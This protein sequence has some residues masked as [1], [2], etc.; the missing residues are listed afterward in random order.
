MRLK[1]FLLILY[2]HVLAV[3]RFHLGEFP[4]VALRVNSK[5]VSIGAGISLYTEL[6][7]AKPGRV[8]FTMRGHSQTRISYETVHVRVP[9]I[10]VGDPWWVFLLPIDWSIRSHQVTHPPDA[11]GN[12]AAKHLEGPAV[13]LRPGVGP[14]PTAKG[15]KKTGLSRPTSHVTAKT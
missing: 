9:C 4:S 5:A 2:L 1:V 8:C 3:V 10:H 11:R 14:F 6:K 13:L 7:I 12:G 15:P